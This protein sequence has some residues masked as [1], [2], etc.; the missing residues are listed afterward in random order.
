MVLLRTSAPDEVGR[1]LSVVK[2]IVMV[3][4]AG[5]EEPGT[6]VRLD[7]TAFG[8]T[9]AGSEVNNSMVELEFALR[10]VTSFDEDVD[11]GL[12]EILGAAVML[13]LPDD[14]ATMATET[15]VM[16]AICVLSTA[17]DVG[18]VTSMLLARLLAVLAVLEVNE[19]ELS[20]IEVGSGVDGAVLQFSTV[21]KHKAELR[22]CQSKPGYKNIETREQVQTHLPQWHGRNMY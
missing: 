6:I 19:L 1:R 15:D 21:A 7:G 9:E 14:V 3:A 22:M 12:L 5:S 17:D 4:D 8:V 2:L 18:A 20:N 13:S 11:V 10:V 16:L